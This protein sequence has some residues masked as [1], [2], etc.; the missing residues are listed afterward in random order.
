VLA[1]N[2]KVLESRNRIARSIVIP[3]KF[4]SR[5]VVSEHNFASFAPKSAVTV[6]RSRGLIPQPDFLEPRAAIVAEKLS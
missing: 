2:V 1:I 4:S 5:L 6:V 3:N